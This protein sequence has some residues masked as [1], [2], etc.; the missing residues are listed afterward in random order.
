VT[1]SNAT[2]D[3][4]EPYE[5]SEVKKSFTPQSKVVVH[6]INP[7]DGSIVPVDKAIRFERQIQIDF[8]Q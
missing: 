3:N 5:L 8:N 1:K 6:F 7:N 2:I 4:V